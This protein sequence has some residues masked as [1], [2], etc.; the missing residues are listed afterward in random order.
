VAKKPAL[1]FTLEIEAPANGQV[2]KSRIAALDKDRKTLT[3]DKAD[4]T[5]ACERDK[6]AARLAKRLKAFG[7]ITP[8]KVAQKLEEAWNDLNDQHR[9]IQE[10]RAAGSPEAAPQEEGGEGEERVSASTRLIQL[11]QKAGAELF[12][13]G[14]TPFARILVDGHREVLAV[15]SRAFRN[16]CRRIYYEAQ[17]RA[18][19]SQAVEDALGVLEAEALFAGAEHA[20][21]IRLAEHDG[22]IYL[23]LADPL[24]RAVEIGPGGWHVVE[25]PPVRFRRGRSTLPLPEPARGGTL[26]ELRPFVNVKTEEDWLLLLGWTLGTLHPRGPY[27]NLLLTGEQGTAKSTLG[28]TLQRAADPNAGDLRCEPKEPRDL[29]IAANGAWLV[30][31][32]NLSHLPQWLSDALCR[33]AT[34][35]GFGTRQLYTDDEEVVFNHKR[36]VLLTSITDVVTAGDLLDRCIAL[37]LETIPDH[38]RKTEQEFDAAFDAAR[39]R[40]LGALLDAVAAGLKTLPTVKLARLQRMADFHLWAEACLQG[41]GFAAGAFTKAYEANR[42]TANRLAL[43]ASQVATELFKLLDAKGPFEGTATE[44][45]KALNQQR[46]GD[47]KR[48]PEG[49][50]ARPHT[51][52]GHLKRLAP[53]L[54]KEGIDV[55]WSTSHHPRIITLGRC[56]QGQGRDGASPASQASPDV[57]SQGKTAGVGTHGDAPGD[58]GDAPGDAERTSENP[59][60]SA[61]RD[62]GDGG[63]AHSRPCPHDD[64]NWWTP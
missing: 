6:S 25:E 44:L 45:L 46:G 37:Q 15:R 27:P 60:F 57:R 61:E 9:R 53:N 4:L 54:R 34:G 16:W 47:E 31:Y 8:A 18:A 20:A 32:D 7:T 51:L 12:R 23:D 5:P 3:T 10:L 19:G 62:A 64:E 48:P 39:P 28:R 11:V 2:G 43:E 26:K 49:W 55:T 22:R 36:P 59:D 50:P 40:I 38:Q 1:E 52:S 21:P 56:P 30:A 24:W 42:G 29:A 35:G 14:E 58:A 33:L 63:D 41:A 17:G 13:C